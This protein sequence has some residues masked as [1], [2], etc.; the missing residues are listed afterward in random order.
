MT[1]EVLERKDREMNAKLNQ[2]AGENHDPDVFPWCL[3]GVVV[4]AIG[5]YVAV[6]ILL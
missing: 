6:G 4:L 5:T 1:D 2:V 3:L